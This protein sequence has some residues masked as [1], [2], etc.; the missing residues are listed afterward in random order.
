MIISLEMIA[1]GRWIMVAP[2]VPY[3]NGTIQK[4]THWW[5]VRAGRHQSTPTVGG[6]GREMAGLEEEHDPPLQINRST[7]HIWIVTNEC[8]REENDVW[9]TLPQTART[10]TR[11]DCS[12]SERVSERKGR[13]EREREGERGEDQTS[14]QQSGEDRGDNRDWQGAFSANGGRRRAAV[15]LLGQRRPEG[16]N[17]HPF[18]IVLGKERGAE[19]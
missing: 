7:T 8:W 13:K 1:P 14:Q 5:E 9:V 2:Q 10:H 3:H 4:E 6:W 19:G 17:T 18:A 16:H 11:L 12:V 15:G